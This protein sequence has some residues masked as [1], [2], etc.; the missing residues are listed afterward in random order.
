MNRIREKSEEYLSH[1]QSGF[2]PNRSTADVAW[3]HKWLAA[4]VQKENMEKFII[5]IDF[6]SAL[7]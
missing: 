5:G 4:K 7:I 6:Y 1:N 3:T 2:I